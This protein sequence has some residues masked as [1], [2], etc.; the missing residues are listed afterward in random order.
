M[1]S[2]SPIID[3]ILDYLGEPPAGGSGANMTTLLR[4]GQAAQEWLLTH[5]LPS[6]LEL[7]GG[8]VD[9]DYPLARAHRVQLRALGNQADCIAACASEAEQVVLLYGVESLLRSNLRHMHVSP[10]E[11]DLQWGLWARDVPMS[12]AHAFTESEFMNPLICEGIAPVC[13]LSAFLV[14]QVVTDDGVAET[15]SHK[16]FEEKPRA[17]IDIVRGIPSSPEA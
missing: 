10:R 13:M 9:C 7:I 4:Q 16:M 2:P 6:W 5:Y 12:I 14:S 17:L 11:R 8:L 1:D 3:N 15:I